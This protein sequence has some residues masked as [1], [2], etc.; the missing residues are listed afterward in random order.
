MLN[1]YM[2]D[3]KVSVDP[4]YGLNEGTTSTAG[5]CDVA[6][7]KFSTSDLSGQC[8]SCN[9]ATMKFARSAFNASTYLC[10]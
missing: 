2:R 1:Y 8:C 4:T 6:C 5:S 3:G 10:K 7:T 9:G